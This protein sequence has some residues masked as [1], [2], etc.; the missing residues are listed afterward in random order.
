MLIDE[1]RIRSQALDSDARR[2]YQ[3]AIVEQSVK[4][5]KLQATVCAARARLGLPAI[6][7]A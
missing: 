7:R 6:V 1:A 5:E 2:I 3:A 4:L